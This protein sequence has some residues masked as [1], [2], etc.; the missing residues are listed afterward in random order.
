MRNMINLF[1][2]VTVNFKV[3]SVESFKRYI[4]FGTLYS[5]NTPLRNTLVIPVG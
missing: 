1:S 5:L 4:N 3:N 2:C